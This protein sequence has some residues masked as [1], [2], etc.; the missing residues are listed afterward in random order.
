MDLDLDNYSYD[1]L[2][3]LFKLPSNFSAAQLK[4]AKKIVFAVHPDK[5]DLP[6]EYFLF[7]LEAY[8]L[9]VQTYTA[10]GNTSFEKY[11]PDE[12]HEKR[13]VAEKFTKSQDFQGKFNQLFEKT[14]IKPEEEAHGYGDWLKSNEDLEVSFQARK[15]DARSIVVAGVAPLQSSY[16][17][18]KTENYASLK[19]IYTSET[20]LSVSEEDF[21][22]K[23]QTADELKH[24]RSV[25]IE[26]MQETEAVQFLAR[27]QERQQE[28]DS[29]RAYS[30]VKQALKH[31]KKVDQFWSHLLRLKD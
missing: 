12:D 6:K 7:F 3:R 9:L 2:V 29:R 13:K 24:A 4:A 25:K 30:M 16:G 5:S 15:K 8:K 10:Q 1:D 14:Y 22:E 21:Q 17:S 20:V 11:E 23:R 27:Q 26:P 18:N 31:E 19:N 28:V